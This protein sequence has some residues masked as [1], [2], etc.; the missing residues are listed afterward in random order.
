MGRRKLS[1][2][3]STQENPPKKGPGR[4]A[5]KQPAPKLPKQLGKQSSH[6]MWSSKEQNKTKL[7]LHHHE[8]EVGTDF[9]SLKGLMRCDMAIRCGC[10]KSCERL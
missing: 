10:L 7:N 1:S 3:G 9:E 5:K 4:R 6:S 8:V 2:K